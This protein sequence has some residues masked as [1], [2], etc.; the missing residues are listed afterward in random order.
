MQY[1]TMVIEKYIFRYHTFSYNT[2]YD[3]YMSI[4]NLYINKLF[5][6]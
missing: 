5:G 1:N 2:T 6:D 3:I 4:I